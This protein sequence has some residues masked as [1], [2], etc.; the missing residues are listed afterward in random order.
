MP[1]GKYDDSYDLYIDLQDLINE[2]LQY[3]YEQTRSTKFLWLDF[4]SY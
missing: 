4:I 3:V 1:L 2:Y